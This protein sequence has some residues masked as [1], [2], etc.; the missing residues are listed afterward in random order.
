MLAAH[1]SKDAVNSASTQM[2][3]VSRRVTDAVDKVRR[4]ETYLELL[5]KATRC[6]AYRHAGD[7]FHDRNVVR[8]ERPSQLNTSYCCSTSR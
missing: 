1:V 7:S 2:N 3:E 8:F 6:G 4:P 5:K